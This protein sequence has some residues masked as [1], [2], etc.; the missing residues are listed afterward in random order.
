MLDMLDPHWKAQVL[1]KRS[2][3][4]GRC[5][6]RF[7]HAEAWAGMDPWCYSSSAT[8]HCGHWGLSRCAKGK[9]TM[10]SLGHLGDDQAAHPGIQEAR[11]LFSQ[12]NTP[13]ATKRCWIFSGSE[14]REEKN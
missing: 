3:G 9:V 8:G 13:K 2:K 5:Q 11:F 14:Q 10:K 6:G 12:V 7:V 1:K 4:E